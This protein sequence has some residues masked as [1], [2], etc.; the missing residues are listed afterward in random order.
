MANIGDLKVGDLVRM[1]AEYP[2]MR[3]QCG[4]GMVIAATPSDSCVKV[5]WFGGGTHD[6]F[7]S[8]CAVGELEIQGEE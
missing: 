1:T 7:E 8:H 6:R 3:S 2:H 5:H 4:L